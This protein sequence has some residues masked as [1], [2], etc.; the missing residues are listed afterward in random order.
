MK[1]FFSLDGEV[2]SLVA[3]VHIIRAIEYVARYVEKFFPTITFLFQ[4]F[5][6]VNLIKNSLCTIVSFFFFFLFASICYKQQIE[7]LFLPLV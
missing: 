3:C 4:T 7:Q 5:R 1:M 2:C 6:F